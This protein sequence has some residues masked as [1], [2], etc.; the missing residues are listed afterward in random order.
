MIKET[1][2]ARFF[3]KTLVLIHEKGFKATTMR[4]IAQNLQFEVA[5]VYNYIDSKQ[6]FLEEALFGIQK[7]FLNAMDVTVDSGLDAPEKLEQLISSYIHITSKRPYEQ[8]LLVNEW[9]NLKGTKLQEFV[10]NRKDYERKFEA[11][12]TQGIHTG[13]F[14]EMEPEIA[15]QTILATLRWSYSRFLDRKPVTNPL[16]MQKQLINFVSH[17]IVHK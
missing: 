9:R 12:I 6:S 14:K 5:N 1:K 11:I 4:D 2:R 7:E 8:A 17:G 13:Y 16:F 10:A 15:T 3:S